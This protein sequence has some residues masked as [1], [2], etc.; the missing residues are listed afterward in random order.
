VKELSI[1]GWMKR[2][3]E[4]LREQHL[5]RTLDDSFPESESEPL[6]PDSEEPTTIPQQDSLS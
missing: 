5:E 4:A 2:G 6:T 3:R 1:D